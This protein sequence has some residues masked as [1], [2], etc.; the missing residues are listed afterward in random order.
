MNNDNEH[1][2]KDIK[3]L[4]TKLLYKRRLYFDKNY[5]LNSE[6]M[7]I[8]IEIT[9]LINR[10][11]PY[12][13]NRIKYIIRNPSIENIAKFAEDLYGSELIESIFHDPYSY[14]YDI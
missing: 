14:S 5:Y 3:Y 12:Y 2:C 7:K 11:F 9:R 4:I 8:L 6:G 10:C 1:I 13:R